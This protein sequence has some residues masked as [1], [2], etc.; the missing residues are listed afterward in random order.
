MEPNHS[1]LHLL[2]NAHIDP[3]WLWEW[4]EGAAEA[5]STFRSAADL[6]EEYD[7]FIFNHNEVLLYEWIEE[8]EPE[9][10]KRIQR[11]VK[12]GRWHIMGGWFLQPDMNLPSGES[13]VRQILLGHSYFTEKFGCWPSTAICFDAFGHSR[14]IVQIMQQAGQ[15]SYLFCRP[16]QNF[17]PLESH[18]FI[19]EG[20]DGS[21]VLAVRGE[22][23]YHSY[24]GKAREKAELCLRRHAGEIASAAHG[25]G[26]EEAKKNTCRNAVSPGHCLWGVGNHGGGPSRKDLDELRQLNSERTD[27]H[28]FHSTPEAYIKELHAA[29][30]SLPRR[31]D[32]LNLWAPGCYISQLRIKQGH[33]ELEQ[34]LFLAEKM[35]THASSAA[36]MTYPADEL[37][38]AMRDLCFVQF[39]D[40]LPG[41]STAPVETHGLRLIHHGLEILSRVRTRAFFA[42]CQGQEKAASGETPILVY[43]PH[44]YPVEATYACEFNL[45]D[46]NWESTWNLPELFDQAGQKVPV[47]LEQESSLLNLDWR[48]KIVFRATLQPGQMNRFNCRTTPSATRPSLPSL[49]SNGCLKFAGVNI[50][51]EISQ[52][53]GLLENLYIDGQRIDAG[54]FFCPE[55]FLDD[56]DPWGSLVT[57]FPDQI[58]AFKLLDEQSAASLC[59]CGSERIDAVRVIED[60]DVRTIIEAYFG[61]RDSRIVMAYKLPKRGSDIEIEVRVFWYQK[62]RLLSLGIPVEGN[63]LKFLGQAMNGTNELITDGQTESVIQQ[64]VGAE[65]PADGHFIGI[66][67]NGTYSV[68]CEP[69]KINLR[70]LRSPA[71]AAHPIEGRQL[72]PKD[73]FLPRIDQGEHLFNFKIVAGGKNSKP[74]IRSQIDRLA[75]EF[76]QVG[77]TLSF[78]PSGDGS[79]PSPAPEIDNPT[80]LLQAFKR[81]EDSICYILRLFNPST[82]NQ[83]TALHMQPDQSKHSISF[84]PFQIKSFRWTR[85]TDMLVEC[86]VLEKPELA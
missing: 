66:I 16:N 70:L 40:I 1:R 48:K 64:W 10:F 75:L 51:A 67:N 85:E 82:H 68:G 7:D 59:S 62:D 52:K 11:L 79:P 45:A 69:N 14:G 55:I 78:F 21:E 33:R 71:Y 63:N 19:W 18:E 23:H 74:S 83:E 42:L 56:A 50:T 13:M 29:N 12:E 17:M 9:L 34:T 5:L 36:G 37:R 72:I 61:Y 26:V 35:A 22:E 57:G 54:D 8:Y 44:P 76:N 81:S 39:H 41:S 27:S 32:D 2:C 30:I 3:V 77:P 60:G 43:N 20:Y 53:T 49:S 86:D 73:R 31:K 24:M 25:I 84:T 80:I 6:C 4:S 28:I 46:Q 65:D 38:E 47:Q 58:D 15:D